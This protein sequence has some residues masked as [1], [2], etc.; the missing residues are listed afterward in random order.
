LGKP[1]ITFGRVFYNVL[2]SVVYSNI[3][4][5]L[6]AIIKKQMTHKVDSEEVIRYVAALM[7]DCP[8]AD[9]LHLWEVEKTHEGR[10]EKLRSVAENLAQ[11]VR[12][13]CGSHTG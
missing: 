13:V 1:V 7:E 2:K 5:E 6:P 4:E 11:K 3:P 10:R 9:L 8:R 12:D